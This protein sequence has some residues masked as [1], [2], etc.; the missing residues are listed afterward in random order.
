MFVNGITDNIQRREEYRHVCQWHHG[1]QQ[2]SSQ[3][4]PRTLAEACAWG[5]R[6]R[7]EYNNSLYGQGSVSRNRY[8]MF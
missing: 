7:L 6:T 4:S 8:C 3:S 2:L 5:R 1:F